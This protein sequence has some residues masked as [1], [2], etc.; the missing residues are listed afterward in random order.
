MHSHSAV[1]FHGSMFVYGGER[2]G[3]LLDE[4]WRYD[5]TSSLWSRITTEK[6]LNPSPRSRHTAVLAPMIPK[7][8]VIQDNSEGNDVVNRGVNRDETF[9][10]FTPDLT[11]ESSPEK[12][13]IGHQPVVPHLNQRELQHLQETDDP[14]LQ[15]TSF[16]SISTWT[17]ELSSCSPRVK[18][19]RPKNSI[20]Q[21]NNPDHNAINSN[22]GNSIPMTRMP[23]IRRSWS[24]YSPTTIHKSTSIPKSTSSQIANTLYRTI[25]RS[26]SRQPVHSVRH[27]NS[28]D[29]EEEDN[30]NDSCNETQ[31][32][33]LRQTQSQ[34][35]SQDYRAF[36][37][38]K[39]SS[40][41][42]S[43]PLTDNNSW[44]LVMYVFG[45]R[46]AGSSFSKKPIS[47]W[48]LYV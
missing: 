34:E 19:R 12:S 40:Q 43:N 32:N 22:E 38:S 6:G 5:F 15:R 39:S 35:T 14:N 10:R 28:Y 18:L 23:P 27:Q 16:I 25:K 36:T 44:K 11:P 20:N 21:A 47:A 3:V 7:S 24:S 9:E 31:N 33:H 29:E 17:L 8:P 4:I 1:N 26:I 46:E 2:K 45:G 13:L 48:K 37:S 30:S 41:S 42:N